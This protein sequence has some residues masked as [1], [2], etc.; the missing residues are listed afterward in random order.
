TALARFGAL[1]ENCVFYILRM[2]EFLHRVGQ[3]RSFGNVGSN[4]R[5]AR[6][7]SSSGHPYT[8]PTLH[9]CDCSCSP[10]ERYEILDRVSA[11]VR[12]DIG[13]PDHLAPLLGFLRNEF[14]EI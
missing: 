2:Y 9:P 4:V 14:P 13:R 5:F 11:S 10:N 3:T 1:L 7:R 6:K 12:L 8:V